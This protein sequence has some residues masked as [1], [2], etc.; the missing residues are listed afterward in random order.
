MFALVF[1][2]LASGY[3]SA[4]DLVGE[5][6]QL[7]SL[8]RAGKLAIG[9]ASRLSEIYFLT[10]RCAEARK[11]LQSHPSVTSVN[12]VCACGGACQGSSGI[13]SLARFKK[14]LDT[15]MKWKEARVQMLWK[16]IDHMPEARYWAL[17]RLRQDAPSFR[18][19]SLRALRTE[20]ELSLESL[21][22]TP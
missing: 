18:D 2:M 21:E 12:L 7:E 17:K 4:A 1:L 14:L 11:I 13:V 20:L 9:Q 15:G 16:K 8:E 19:P 10:S 6:L 22:V 3:V 5:T